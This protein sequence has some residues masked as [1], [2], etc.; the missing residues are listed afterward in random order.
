MLK[1]SETIIWEK[2]DRYTT[3]WASCLFMLKTP[4]G[5]GCHGFTYINN[6]TW[7]EQRRSCATL[8]FSPNLNQGWI[9]LNLYLWSLKCTATV[10]KKKRKLPRTI[11]NLGMVG[12]TVCPLTVV[13]SPMRILLLIIHVTVVTYLHG[14][15]TWDRVRPS[16]MFNE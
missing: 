9:Y 6:W 11:S 13:K 15:F 1:S 14:Y 3:N 16:C 12:I 8:F 7:N 10:V 2:V 4:F 5:F